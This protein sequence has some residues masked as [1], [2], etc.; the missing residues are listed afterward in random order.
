MLDLSFWSCW[1]CS[2]ICCSFLHDGLFISCHP[3]PWSSP[4]HPAMTLKE[5]L[6]ASAKHP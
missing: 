6:P 3:P 5:P 4:H 2:F 1:Y